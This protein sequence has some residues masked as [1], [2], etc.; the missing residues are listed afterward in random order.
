[1]QSNSNNEGAC[2]YLSCPYCYFD[3]R[4]NMKQRDQLFGIIRSESSM[5]DTAMSRDPDAGSLKPCNFK[6]TDAYSVHATG[7][8]VTADSSVS[9]IHRYCEKLP[10][11]TYGCFSDEASLQNLINCFFFPLFSEFFVILVYCIF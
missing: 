9:L 3:Y 4:G 5:I 7:A 6:G 2:L 11:D 8:L 1:M 10:S